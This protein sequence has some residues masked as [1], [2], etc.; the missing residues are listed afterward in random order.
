VGAAAGTA[1]TAVSV[2]VSRPMHFAGLH[3][4][5]VCCCGI[6]RSQAPH[7]AK[8]PPWH[9]SFSGAMLGSHLVLQVCVLWSMDKRSRIMLLMW[10]LTASDRFSRDQGCLVTQQAMLAV[11][12]LYKCLGVCPSVMGVATWSLCCCYDTVAST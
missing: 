9:R 8:L 4:V 6:A 12:W 1:G 10:L 11:D 3:C 5:V 2:V 7:A